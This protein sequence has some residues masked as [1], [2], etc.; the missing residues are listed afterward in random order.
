MLLV[1]QFTEDTR[2]EV[3]DFF[4]IV[5]RRLKDIHQQH[6]N[7]LS[8]GARKV[9]KRSLDDT[10]ISDQPVSNLLERLRRY[11]S[12]FGEMKFL[13]INCCF[14]VVENSELSKQTKFIDEKG[15]TLLHC[16]MPLA[17]KPLRL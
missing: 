17:D 12:N 1:S 8:H 13:L 7:L 14:G 16:F 15:F 9:R 11:R 4:C 5:F 6:F 10:E 2:R 3:V